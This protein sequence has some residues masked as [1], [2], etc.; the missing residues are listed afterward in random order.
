M[1]RLSIITVCLISALAINF[2]N[3]ST[4]PLEPGPW[5]HFSARCPPYLANIFSWENSTLYSC[6]F[7]EGGRVSGTNFFMNVEPSFQ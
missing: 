1:A 3:C 2:V 6:H 5:E 7:R 4:K